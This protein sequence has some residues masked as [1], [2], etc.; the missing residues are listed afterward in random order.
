MY[1]NTSMISL[2]IEVKEISRRK[3]D[4]NADLQDDFQGKSKERAKKKLGTQ[5]KNPFYTP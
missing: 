1:Q 3:A 4:P 5:I 2:L